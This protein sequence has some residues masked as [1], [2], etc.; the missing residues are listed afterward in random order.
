MESQTLPRSAQRKGKRRQPQVAGKFQLDARKKFSVKVVVV[1]CRN[2][3]PS[4]SGYLHPW[5]F[6]VLDWE[7]LCATRSDVEVSPALSRGWTR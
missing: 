3:L 6:S 7:W 2:R 1:Q 5:R 4:E